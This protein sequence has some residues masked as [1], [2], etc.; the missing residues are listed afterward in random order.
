MLMARKR[1]RPAENRD[2]KIVLEAE[3]GARVNVKPVQMGGDLIL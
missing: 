1:I 3:T 2:H